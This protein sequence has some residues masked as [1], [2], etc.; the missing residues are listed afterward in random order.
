MDYK[1]KYIKYKQKYLNLVGG[2]LDEDLKSL[3]EDLAGLRESFLT[4]TQLDKDQVVYCIS[5]MKRFAL[6]MD[7]EEKKLRR[8]QFFYQIG[9]IQELL[10]SKPTI[11]WNPFEKLITEN[12][13]EEIKRY[14][15]ILKS[16]IGCEYNVEITLKGC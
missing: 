5:Q 11:W 8:Y 3:D 14:V 16:K 12:N 4:L 1:T 7:N 10:K 2:N 9:R 13:Y 15:D 6:C